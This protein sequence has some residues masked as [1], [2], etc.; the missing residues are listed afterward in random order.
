MAATSAF[1]GRSRA[2]SGQGLTAAAQ[3]LGTGLAEL[4]AV[5]AVETSGCG[6]DA[7]RRTRILYER[8]IFHRL[9]GGRFD[10]GD[11]SDAHP[12]GYGPEGAHQYERLTR[13]MQFDRMA[14][15][16]SSS[17]GLGQ[18][19]GTNYQQAG[20]ADIDAFV[21]AMSDSEDAQLSA[22]SAFIAANGL[23]ASLR[24]HDWTAFARGYNGPEFA[25][26]EYDRKLAEEH[27]K[28]AAG[29]LPDL[30]VR[31]LQLY[32]RYLGFDPG[33]VDGRMGASTRGAIAQCEQRLGLPLTSDFSSELLARLIPA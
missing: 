6:Y 3:Q 15:L 29:P 10:D 31:A 17:W 19:L 4:W 30:D 21:Q 5:L 26:N 14:A 13:A 25:R 18:V 22:M 23:T 8:H 1:V 12:G 7:D 11:I 2:L 9:T 28:H 32:L 33:P 24:T 20:F 16:K 27:R